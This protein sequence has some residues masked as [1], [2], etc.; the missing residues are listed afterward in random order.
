MT[1][2]PHPGVEV[3]GEWRDGDERVLTEQSLADRVTR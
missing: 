2:S 3:R 1:S